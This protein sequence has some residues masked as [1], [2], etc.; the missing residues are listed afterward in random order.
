MTKCALLSH[1]HIHRPTRTIRSAVL[2]LNRSK[3]VCAS[4]GFM[5]FLLSLSISL[6]VFIHLHG[7]QATSTH[8]MCMPIH[9]AAAATVMPF[10]IV[11]PPKNERNCDKTLYIYTHSHPDIFGGTTHLLLRNYPLSKN[12]STHVT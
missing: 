4:I 11:K 7:T 12:K 10:H 9:F 8:K 2:R 3:S 1:T 5:L 6:Y